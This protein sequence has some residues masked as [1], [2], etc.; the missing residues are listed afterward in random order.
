MKRYKHVLMIGGLSL[1]TIGSYFGYA[2]MIKEPDYVIESVQGKATDE[3]V[4]NLHIGISSSLVKPT[5][6][7][8]QLDGTIEVSERN[9]LTNLYDSIDVNYPK[10]FYRFIRKEDVST[11]EHG[12]RTY[13]IEAVKGHINYQSYDEMTKKYTKVRFPYVE[14]KA[15][16]HQD[17]ET[18]FQI[19]SQ[20]SGKVYVAKD[21]Y[22]P[23]KEMKILQ[24]DIEKR[25]VSEIPLALPPLK[26]D[27]SRTLITANAYGTLYLLETFEEDTISESKYYL[28]NGK[29]VKRI[30]A[31]DEFAYTG[32]MDSIANNRQL[33]MYS[34]PKDGSKDIVW[35]VYDFETNKLTE[36][37]VT[38]KY[39]NRFGMTQIFNT[40][41]RLYQVSPIDKSNFQVTV[42]D[43]TDDSIE[44]QGV[45]RDKNEQEGFQIQD[46]RIE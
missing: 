17:S 25:D 41:Q 38:G 12:T 2:A 10:E 15:F 5:Q 1:V 21:A 43:I 19:L 20:E 39:S 7:D 45:I 26:K 4:K 33:V 8:V 32:S 42:I 11:S 3:A 29:T 16:R 30:K 34:S 6:Y 28:D 24:L 18:P 23:D 46:F 40:N 9:Y 22:G 14:G 37:R 36:H 31:L 44:Y 27:Q 35:N 13:G